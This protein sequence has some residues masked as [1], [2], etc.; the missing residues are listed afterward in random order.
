[1]HPVIF[2]GLY[3][4]IGPNNASAQKWDLWWRKRKR[5]RHCFPFSF[6]PPSATIV[7]AAFFCLRLFPPFSPLL[8]CS[9]V[10]TGE[11]RKG[12]E[13]ESG[14]FSLIFF[15]DEKTHYLGHLIFIAP[16]PF[17]VCELLAVCPFVSQ[18]LLVLF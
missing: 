10:K 1:M 9:R 4:C 11:R 12:E 8:F 14:P 7:V 6:L 16:V 13:E 17:C 3:T 18:G 5:R 2:K 15:A